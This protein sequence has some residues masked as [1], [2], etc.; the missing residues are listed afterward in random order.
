MVA[1]LVIAQAA[2]LVVLLI[3][4]RALQRRRQG[5]CLM[6]VEKVFT[7]MIGRLPSCFL[8]S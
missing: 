8:C 4:C 2:D 7:P 1:L 5:R 3:A 6:R